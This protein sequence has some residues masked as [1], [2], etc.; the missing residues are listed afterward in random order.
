MAI[1]KCL[2]TQS[3][4]AATSLGMLR[5]SHANRNEH[6]CRSNANRSS[7]IPCLRGLFKSFD[8]L[9]SPKESL[10]KQ[11]ERPPQQEA[12]ETCVIVGQ[13]LL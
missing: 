8:L 11:L 12:I 6:T 1:C 5:G 4:F 3:D 7:D 13:V 2:D 9:C 10:I